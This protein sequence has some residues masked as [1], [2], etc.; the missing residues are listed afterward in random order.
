MRRNLAL[1]LASV[2]LAVGSYAISAFAA[3]VPQGPDF[4]AA[5]RVPA[6]TFKSDA[7]PQA[8]CNLAN[9]AGT[10]SP[11][12]CATV[13][14]LTLPQTFAAVNLDGGGGNSGVL[15]LPE[16]SATTVVMCESANPNTHACNTQVLLPTTG[17]AGAV[18]VTCAGVESGDGGQAI[19]IRLN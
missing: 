3:N 6:L 10:A 11:A 14:T 7:G 15:F 18:L 19:C 8:G 16:L 17:D 5:P 12:D 9:D 13:S 2:G 1:L 4:T